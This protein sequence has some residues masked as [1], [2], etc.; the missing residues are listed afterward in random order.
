[1]LPLHGAALCS[2]LRFFD[3]NHFPG[4]ALGS[5]TGLARGLQSTESLSLLLFWAPAHSE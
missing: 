5:S 1:M 4:M 2:V 3:M